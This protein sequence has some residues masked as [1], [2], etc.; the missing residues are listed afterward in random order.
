MRF[1]GVVVG[2]DHGVPG[3]GL[4]DL[5]D[6]LEGVK[7]LTLAD[8]VFVLIIFVRVALRDA[9]EP[10]LLVHR[11]VCRR[12]RGPAGRQVVDVTVRPVDKFTNLTFIII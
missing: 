12:L 11:G 9:E 10:E 8:V 3:D 5:F 2:V 7:V 6:G 1:A 4:L